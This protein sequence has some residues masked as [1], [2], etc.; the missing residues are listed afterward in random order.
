[1]EQVRTMKKWRLNRKVFF[2]KLILTDGPA[3]TNFRHSSIFLAIFMLVSS[4]S[5]QSLSPEMHFSEDGHMLLTGGIEDSGLYNTQKVKTIFLYFSQPDYWQLM[6]SLYWTW[7][8]EEIPATMV[9]DGITYD[10]VG[11]RFKGQS[12]YQEIPG[13]PKKSFSISMDFVYGGQTLMG[14]KS[15]NLHNCYKDESFMREVFYENRIKNHIPAAKA[16]FARLFINGENWGLYANVQQINKFFF[17]QWYLS[18][19][20]TSWRA[21]RDDGQWAPDGNGKSALNYL[22]TDTV[23]YQ[24]EYDL[25]FTDK[26]SPWNDLLSAC[27][28]L[29]NPPLPDLPGSLPPVLDIDRALWFLASEILFADDDSYVQKGRVDYYFYWEKETGR[30]APQEYDGNGVMNPDNLTWS[31]FYHEENVNYPLMNRL[32]SVPEYRQRYL[33]H[34]RTL[35]KEYFTPSSADSIIDSYKTLIDTIVQNDSK[36]L[37]TYQDFLDEI[38]L[39]KT[40]ISDRKNFLEN[41]PEVAQPGP[42]ISDVAWYADGIPWAA[43]A[44]MQNA[45]VRAKIISGAGVYRVNL[46]YSDKLV[47]NF[48]KVQ[49]FDDG[50]HGDLLPADGIYVASIP[51]MPEGTGVRFYVEAVAGNQSQTVSYDPPGAEHNV[52]FYYTGAFSSL[53]RLNETGREIIVYPNPGNGKFIIARVPLF[54]E[55]LNQ[56]FD[57]IVIYN[58]RGEKVYSESSCG[59]RHHAAVDIS[60]FAKGLYF[61]EV[62]SGQK[63]YREKIVIL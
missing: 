24:E 50:Q 17:K 10:S 40:F 12:S 55:N 8:K 38:P 34:L 56:T 15:L 33:A 45:L 25:K 22:G 27:D 41:N 47:G 52:Y 48:S 62:Y 20:G 60:R 21:E 57:A 43:P 46:Y 16:A 5:P 49:M 32:F 37:Y 11:V 54:S 61:L 23:L 3:K 30:I 13:S 44:A 1:M 2:G 58:T 31:P 35:I 51:G 6:D 14:Y 28:A 53:Q 59:R 26:A 39:L 7:T 19:K 29:N 42:V 36:K 9:V 4:A 63:A 18:S